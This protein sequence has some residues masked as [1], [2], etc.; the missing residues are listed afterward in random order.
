MTLP[1]DLPHEFSSADHHDM[2]TEPVYAERESLTGFYA[3]LSI[4]I[5]AFLSL[6]AWAIWRILE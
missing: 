6:T 3:V 5:F 1:P 4:S 2:D